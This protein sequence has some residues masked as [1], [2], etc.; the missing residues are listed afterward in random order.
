MFRESGN[1]CRTGAGNRLSRKSHKPR[2]HL[3]R[4]DRRPCLHR[5]RQRGCSRQPHI[6]NC[7]AEH[8]GFR[9]T[10]SRTRLRRS[11]CYRLANFKATGMQSH[12]PYM[13]APAIFLHK[14][15]TMRTLPPPKRSRQPDERRIVLG[16]HTLALM[17]L[18]FALRARARHARR[19]DSLMI[20]N[21]VARD[22]RRALLPVTVRLLLCTRLQHLG[23]VPL[24]LGLREVLFGILGRE[25]GAA[26]AHREV[27]RGVVHRVEEE[28]G[29]ASAAFHV[30]AWLEGVD[31]GGREVFLASRACSFCRRWL[32]GGNGGLLSR[33][34][35][36]CLGLD[37]GGRREMVM[38]GSET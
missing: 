31:L 24:G 27:V 13:V 29:E 28:N 19:T 7:C 38:R 22:E 5:H 6:D 12:L 33:A 35:G 11:T 1:H 21:A 26:A 2:S 16:P 3:N 34:S 14:A 10:C 20:E 32:A 30:P 36:E 8:L 17:P 15:P 23:L 9:R 4:T 37:H 18:G 25:Q